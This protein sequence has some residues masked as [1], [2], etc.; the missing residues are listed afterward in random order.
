VGALAVIFTVM[1]SL[2]SDPRDSVKRLNESIAQTN[3]EVT[4]ALVLMDQVLTHS[5]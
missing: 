2:D 5:S 1:L 3:R 4:Q